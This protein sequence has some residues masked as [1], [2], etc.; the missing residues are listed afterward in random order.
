MFEGVLKRSLE[1]V[2][3]SIYADRTKPSHLLES[4][5]FSFQYGRGVHGPKRE[6]AG[7]SGIDCASFTGVEAR[8]GLKKILDQLH[9]QSELLPA[10]P[11][12]SLRG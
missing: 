7:L 9:I 6:R 8:S 1:G 10:L 11:R 12:K 4:Y 3:F 5:T 2:Q